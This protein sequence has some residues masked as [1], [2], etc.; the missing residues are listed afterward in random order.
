[1]SIPSGLKRFLSCFPA[2][3]SS[4]TGATVSDPDGEDIISGLPDDV[5]S[6][7]VS[8][9]PINDAARTAALSSRW[10]DLWASNPLVLDDIDLL[11]NNP[12]HVGAVTSTVSHAITAHP[13]PFR[14]VK[15][16]CYFS[17]ADES[18]LHHW[19]RVLAAK[20]VTELVLNNIPWAGLDLLPCA[21]LECRSL[22]RLRISEWRFPDTSGAAAVLRQGV[23][24][25]PRLRELVLR[26]SIIQEQDLD[27]V[28][29]S[30]PKLKNLVFV[31]SR[32]APA[33]VRLS[34]RSLWCVV[35]WQ[36][37]VEELAVV[38]A[39]LLERIILRTS[40]SPC[41]ING[42]D[43]SC[44]RIKISS[45]SVLQ[46]L[47]YLN[48]NYHELQIGDTVVKVGM[49]VVPD[50]VVPSV[51]ILALSIQFGVPNKARMM[52][53][54]LRCFP[55][56][57]TMHIQAFPLLIPSSLSSSPPALPSSPSLSRHHPL[58]SRRCRP[59][60]LLPL[61]FPL[62]SSLT[63]MRSGSG[64]RASGSARGSGAEWSGANGAE[65]GGRG[66]GR[67]RAEAGTGTGGGG[68]R[69]A[70]ARAEAEAGA[71][72]GRGGSGGQHARAA[73]GWAGGAVGYGGGGNDTVRALVAEGGRSIPD[74]G[75]TSKNGNSD[76]WNEI[77][78][79]KC[80]KESINKVVI[81]GFRWENCEIE[82]LKSILEGGNVLQKIYILQDKNVTVSEGAI[83]GTLSL[84]ASLKK[85]GVIALM[86]LA[87]QDGIWSYEMASDVSR[88]DPFDC[89]S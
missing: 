52:S 56:I 38:A 42:K 58:T 66:R 85:K 36:S 12:S 79:V 71:G 6:S 46:A 33:Q 80:I 1:M 40:S 54:F 69:P 20:G 63:G 5:L 29:A 22:Q 87:G 18:T 82:F 49:K 61:L 83:N 25:L 48:P 57:E 68:R 15:L 10:R 47:G 76:F 41:G 59:L 3:S 55:N 21:I 19:I 23:A 26:R 51:K 65:A 37:V 62:C 84:L 8:L 53:C 11:L 64:A 13:G 27:R 88:N 7:I 70:Q 16:T 50:A 67:R 44:M 43:G 86:I 17:D 89:Q 34:S 45:A 14:S 74:R 35:F 24:A 78:S 31:L 28:L 81:H 73:G 4:V 39:P 77:D 9:L 2:R 32:G 30:S 72:A 75:A 60:P